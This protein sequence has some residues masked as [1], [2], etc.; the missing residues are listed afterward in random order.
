MKSLTHKQIADFFSAHVKD[1]GLMVEGEVVTR[2]V[3]LRQRSTR[4]TD[5]KW[6]RF[7]YKDQ[8]C[9]GLENE[10]TQNLRSLVSKFPMQRH[11]GVETGIG[12]RFF[13]TRFTEVNIEVINNR[14]YTVIYVTIKKKT[15]TKEQPEEPTMEEWDA[16]VEIQQRY[17]VCNRF[18]FIPVHRGIDTRG[19]FAE[20][21]DAYTVFGQDNIPEWVLYEELIYPT[22]R[23]S[24]DAMYF[25][26]LQIKNVYKVMVLNPN[27]EQNDNP[28]AQSVFQQCKK[29][30]DDITRIGG[31]LGS[32]SIVQISRRWAGLERLEGVLPNPTVRDVFN[33][34]MSGLL[35][36]PFTELI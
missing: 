1:N 29:R 25:C 9:E 12:Y 22:I 26:I 36:G 20:L 16:A 34:L 8:V 21:N 2:S 35:A 15:V 27:A 18:E 4:Y 19:R 17:N 10:L 14:F 24:I 33:T 5:I 13:Y 11:A 6:S 31:I 32:D 3:V 7:P 30:L 23:R 28:L